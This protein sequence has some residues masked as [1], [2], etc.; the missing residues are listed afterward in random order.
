MRG[1]SLIFG[2][3]IFSKIGIPKSLQEVGGQFTTK[4]YI[5]PEGKPARPR[6]KESFC[7]WVRERRNDVNNVSEVYSESNVKATLDDVREQIKRSFMSYKWKE[8]LPGK[9]ILIK[10]CAKHIN[11]LPQDLFRNHIITSML[12]L[13]HIPD[14]IHRLCN[15]IKKSQ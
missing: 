8:L 11:G 9:E 12:Q 6:D 4:C 13:D 10:F 7:R 3:G 5:M 14:E 1:K 2:H 15:F